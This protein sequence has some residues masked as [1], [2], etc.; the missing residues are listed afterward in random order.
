[1][2]HPRP[3]S[4]W[5]V[6]DAPPQTW[7]RPV[8]FLKPPKDRSECDE[9]FPL[10]PAAA[11]FSYRDGPQNAR[12]L[13]YAH[14]VD[15]G[16]DQHLVQQGRPLSIDWTPAL[17]GA[18]KR[19][20]E[21][22]RERIFGPLAPLQ[23]S[24]AERD[25][26]DDEADD[27]SQPEAMVIPFVDPETGKCELVVARPKPEHRERCRAFMRRLASGGSIGAAATKAERIAARCAATARDSS[28]VSPHVFVG[29][30]IAEMRY[31]AEM[32]LIDR[33]VIER[34]MREGLGAP[35]ASEL[36][37]MKRSRALFR[38]A[39]EE[40]RAAAFWH[41]VVPIAEAAGISMNLPPPPETLPPPPTGCPGCGIGWVVAGD[42][43]CRRC[44]KETPGT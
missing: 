18:S 2:P 15:M 21:A 20:K 5:S 35:N 29:R 41:R 4:D 12:R 24:V 33:R 19:F 32:P 6:E 34:R 3:W 26:S 8:A 22:L 1:M 37:Q 7:Q 25:L 14:Q 23:M 17:F 38:E 36:A 40:Q 16:N 30:A 39:L 42:E 28:L 10:L 9:P 13:F 44:P 11:A 43:R 27:E 31:R